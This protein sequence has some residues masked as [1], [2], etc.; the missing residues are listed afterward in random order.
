[1]TNPYNEP[2]DAHQFFLCDCCCDA[3]L[4]SKVTLVDDE[5][6]TEELF[7]SIWSRGNG[8]VANKLPLKERIRWAFRML[9][10]GNP[11]GDEVTLSKEKVLQL[12]DWLTQH[13]DAK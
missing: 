12:R 2:D 7:I 6:D 1:M 8:Y 3:L 11:Y 13:Y 4:L 10:N 9:W 5:P